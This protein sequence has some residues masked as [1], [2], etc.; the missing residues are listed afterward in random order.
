MVV[1]LIV[2]I[3]SILMA[4]QRW[5]QEASVGK[6]LI[7]KSRI[8]KHK[9]LKMKLRAIQSYKKEKAGWNLAKFSHGDT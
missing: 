3:Y 6:K 8:K 5:S 4:W 7:S 1:R 9:Q 2:R